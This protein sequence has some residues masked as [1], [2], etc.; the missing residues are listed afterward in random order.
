MSKPTH[1]EVLG[2]SREAPL[3]IIKATHRAWMKEVHPDTGSDGDGGKA[4]AVNE[5]YRIL[6]N[7]EARAQYDAA[8][9]SEETATEAPADQTDEDPD[10]G[11]GTEQD[12]GWGNEGTA[13]TKPEARPR[14]TG[15][16]PKDFE[17][18]DPAR[19]AGYSIFD[20]EN[21][22]LASMNWHSRDYGKPAGSPF[23]GTW[24]A[25]FRRSTRFWAWLAFAALT[26]IYLI[27]G[28]IVAFVPPRATD[29]V[30]NLAIFVIALPAL[31]LFLG[32]ARARHRG[33]LIRY[34]LAILAG[35]ATTWYMADTEAGLDWMLPATWLLLYIATVE[36]FHASSRVRRKSPSKLLSREGFS[37]F[38]TWGH[39]GGA[40]SKS[41]GR[42]A[43]SNIELGVAG[44][45]MTGQLLAE[46]VKIPGV[47]ILHGLVFPGS[48]DGGVDHAVLCGSRL[49]LIDS[50]H[51]RS[52]DYYW[53]GP[54]LLYAR[55]NERAQ[56]T[57]TNFPTA[58]A[59][60]RHH[61]P[62]LQVRGWYVLH[63]NDG[64]R[65]RTNNK[66]AGDKPRLLA[67]APFLEEIGDWLAEG[68]TTK[69]SRSQLS[70]LIFEFTKAS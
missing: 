16:Q 47:K 22:N 54:S 56:V 13:S 63:S 38:N 28:Y 9:R 10:V 8:L 49:A 43:P 45:I 52:G 26:L 60:Y 58:V 31:G 40:I 20:R 3:H 55:P 34:I 41:S 2:V 32:Q 15:G 25:V 42:F 17:N 39:P 59:T 19:L 65:M 27:P 6:R 33:G 18:Q 35:I 7:P 53:L 69:T 30:A 11:W 23:D 1:Y 57:P 62:K 14:T 36:L 67:P 70:R 44:E 12:I 50:K 68:A 46:L 5:A 24:T 37:R 48:A 21:F 61:F 51:W 4:A 64:G 29:W 66:D